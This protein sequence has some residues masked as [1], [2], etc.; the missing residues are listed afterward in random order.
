MPNTLEKIVR[1][2]LQGVWVPVVR[3]A[4]SIRRSF[5]AGKD[6]THKAA[7]LGL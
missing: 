7:R 1:Y 2:S 5:Q 6:R 4:A 3:W